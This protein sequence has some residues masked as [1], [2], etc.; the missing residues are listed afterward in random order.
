MKREFI[1][2]A[3]ILLKKWQLQILHT[4]SIEIESYKYKG[5]ELFNSIGIQVALQ[6]HRC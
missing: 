3:E 6:I 4:H 1:A 5:E 2:G